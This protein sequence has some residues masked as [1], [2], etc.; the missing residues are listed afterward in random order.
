[1]SVAAAA[2]TT[3]DLGAGA[4]R[5]HPAHA[6]FVAPFVA[7]YALL[8]LWPLAH[9]A[10]MSLRDQDLLSEDSLYLGLEN[11][12]NLFTDEIFNQ[13]LWNT[14]RFVAVSV[15]VFMVVALALALVL[16]RPGRTG[17]VLR[18][19]FF[20]ASVLSVTIVTL[21]W[22]LALMPERGL[23]PQLLA[24]LGL[25]GVSFLTSEALALPTVAFITVW[26][27]IGLPM[28]LFLS[29]LQQIP[30]ELYEAAALDNAGRWRTL[31]RIT[32]PSLKRTLVLVAVIEVIRQCQVFPQ[33]MLLTA[34][35]PNNSSRPI[36]QFIY[37]QAFVEL[38]LGYASAASQILLAVMMVGVSLQLWLERGAQR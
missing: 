27:I 6:L 12:E 15:P 16:N 11:F 28:M 7:L 35:G 9:G 37:E 20:S 17:T 1:M 32:L 26:W 36:V 3:A 24:S 25:E 2:M 38:S 10:W 34:G 31:T 23:L 5:S 8:V 33:I 21:V 18:A 13:V 4:K 14:A 30:H 22:R 29:A 19:V